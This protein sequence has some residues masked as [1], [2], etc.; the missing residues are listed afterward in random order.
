[1]T[2]TASRVNCG[3]KDP[4]IV[5]ILDKGQVMLSTK[6][7]GIPFGAKETDCRGSLVERRR[8]RG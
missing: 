7:F 3:Q 1:M 4:D 8:K 5:E 2:E 6:R